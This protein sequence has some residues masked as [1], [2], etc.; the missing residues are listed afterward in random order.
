MFILHFCYSVLRNGYMEDC[1]IYYII[2]CIINIRVTNFINQA[3]LILRFIMIR[4]VDE[5][6]LRAFG[7]FSVVNHVHGV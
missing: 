4:C 7:N 1:I 6:A 2:Y 3:K 5:G